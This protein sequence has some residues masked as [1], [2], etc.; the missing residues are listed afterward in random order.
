MNLDSVGPACRVGLGASAVRQAAPT[1]DP[2]ILFFGN[3][4][5][6]ENRTSSHQIA[7][8]LAK[9]FRVYY[10]ECPGLRAPT[11]S[12]RDFKKILAKLGRFLR[13]VRPVKE[14][15]KVRTL[16]QLPFHRFRL[17]RRLNQALMLWTVRRLMRREGIRN[18]ITWFMVPHLSS[19]VGELGERLSVY[20]CIDD[21]AALP[22]VNS[23]A[24]KAMDE[25][26]T[27]KADLVFVASETLL[28]AKRRL[29]SNTYVSPH[30]VDFEHFAR[31]Q[32]DSPSIPGDVT[33]L[34]RPIVGF[35][36]LIERWIDL[37]LVEYLA[38]KRPQWTFVLIGRVAVPEDQV[39]R[40][41]NIHYLGQRDYQE[42]PAYGKQF[43]VSIIPYRLTQ[44]VLHANPIKLR[45][46]LAMGKPVVSVSTP[47]ID[48][49]AD[50]VAIAR[51]REEFLIK[52]DAVLASPPTPE[53]TGRRMSRVASEDWD[54]RLNE[55]LEITNQF[56]RSSLVGCPSSV[57]HSS[58]FWSNGQNSAG[59]E[60]QRGNK[61]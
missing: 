57:V 22:H 14:G 2:A 50:V 16:L 38:E 11:G 5:F 51:T 31:A 30:G 41:P 17:V 39:P 37:E 53:E 8:W 13:G 12:G 20:Y 40:R 52:I 29:N 19:L 18:P 9:R 25:E 28:E 10:L 6:A 36:G 15:L 21:Y 34:P 7:R 44:Q 45:E 3:D 43:D 27:R 32:G 33:N 1:L 59:P 60:K 46:Y 55:V 49:Y 54:S 48:K 35:F 23:Q 42:L 24:V 26:L 4:W 58:V 47:E 61:R 56:P